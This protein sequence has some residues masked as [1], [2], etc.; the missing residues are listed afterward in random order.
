MVGV[1]TKDSTFQVQFEK[2]AD[3]ADTAVQFFM[4][5]LPILYMRNP[6]FMQN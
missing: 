6:L 4:L 5:A 1:T 3:A 2:C